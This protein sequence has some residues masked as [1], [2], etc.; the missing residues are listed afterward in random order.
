MVGHRHKCYPTLHINHLH[1][2]NYLILKKYCAETGLSKYFSGKV[3]NEPIVYRFLFA[4]I[5]YILSY[6]ACF[7]ILAYYQWTFFG[8]AIGIKVLAITC[9]FDVY[10]ATSYDLRLVQ[11]TVDVSYD[12]P[13]VFISA[14]PPPCNAPNEE[15]SLALEK[16]REEEHIK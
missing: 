6:W 5:G 15:E 16:R 13:K 12:V 11:V 4:C 1:Q 8:V 3:E 2:K 10:P 14:N 9:S 7:V